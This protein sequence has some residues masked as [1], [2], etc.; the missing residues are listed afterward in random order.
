MLSSAT[1][2]EIQDVID[3]ASLVVKPRLQEESDYRLV[4]VL[5]KLCDSA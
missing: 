4:R 1:Q 5:E 3:L 2:N